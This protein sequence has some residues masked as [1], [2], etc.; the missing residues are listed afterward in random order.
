MSVDGVPQ[1]DIGSEKT[2]TIYCGEYLMRRNPHL[3]PRCELLEKFRYEKE[4]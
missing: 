3:L 1:R 2:C 4:M